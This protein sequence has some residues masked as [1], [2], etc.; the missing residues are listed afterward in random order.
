MKFILAVLIVLVATASMAAQDMTKGMGKELR[1]ELF[2]L[3]SMWINGKGLA[4]VKD[5]PTE[6]L[7]LTQECNISVMKPSA[8]RP[9][10]VMFGHNK[11]SKHVIIYMDKKGVPVYLDASTDRVG[12]PQAFLKADDL[13]YADCAKQVQFY[14]GLPDEL[15][16]L[17][18]GFQGI[19]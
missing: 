19:R 11:S 5:A 1:G 3:G 13:A 6:V 16:P 8:Y 2:R 18:L 4:D 15:R 17:F 14:P 9:R 7:Y 10:A 12:Q